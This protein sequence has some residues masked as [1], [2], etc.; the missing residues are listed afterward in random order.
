MSPRILVVGLSCALA[1]VVTLGAGLLEGPG[2]AAPVSIGKPAPPLSLDPLEAA[3]APALAALRGK[4]VVVNFFATWCEGCRAED[5]ARALD[6]VV[7]FVGVAED[8][9]PDAVRRFLKDLGSAYPVGLDHQAKTASAWGAAGLPQTFVLD[10]SGTLVSAHA[11]PLDAPGLAQLL[12]PL[13]DGPE[14]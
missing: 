5:A 11:G 3:A 1:L 10:A 6:G 8:E 9:D 2:I 7:R 13:V 14:R 12:R 4:P